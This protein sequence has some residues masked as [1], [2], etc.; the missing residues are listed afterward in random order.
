MTLF[1]IES[2]II[3]K[4]RCGELEHCIFYVFISMKSGIQNY[5]NREDL[6]SQTNRSFYR[7]VYFTLNS[8]VVNAL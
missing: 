8:K 3:A 4:T 2:Y 7:I 5:V 1:L 6:G